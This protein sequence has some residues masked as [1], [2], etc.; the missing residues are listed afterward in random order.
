MLFAP[1][2][3]NADI[4]N[5]C[6]EYVESQLGDLP[7]MAYIQ[8]HT[9]E[10]TPEAGDVVYFEYEKSYGTLP[11]VAVVTWSNPD[12]LPGWFLISE[13]NMFHLYPTGIGSR[14]VS[15]GYKHL[16]GFYVI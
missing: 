9:I 16:K 4:H 3:A 8:T 14:F 5:N 11:H 15:T 2:F 10:K 1:I 7:S 6:Y 13:S 12:I